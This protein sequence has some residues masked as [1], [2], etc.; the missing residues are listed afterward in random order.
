VLPGKKGEWVKLFE[1]EVL[2]F[3]VSK[4]MVI[5]GSFRGEEDSSVWAV[6][7]PTRER[8]IVQGRSRDRLLEEHIAPKVPELI[9][10]AGVKM[11]PPPRRPS[12]LD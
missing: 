12:V 1:E 6:A 3:Q 4:G 7:P 5:A 8:A 2:P 10:R 11:Q 9:D